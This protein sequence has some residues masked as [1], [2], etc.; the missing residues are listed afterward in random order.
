MET[1]LVLARFWGI[2]LVVLCGSLLVNAKF[3]VRLV[4]GFQDE[5]V[6]FLYFFVVLVIGAVNVSVVNQ[7]TWNQAGLITLLGWGS[8]LKGSFGIL[9]PDFSNKIIQKVRMS[10]A[11]IYP[12]G[13]VFLLV[14]CYL[15]FCGFVYKAGST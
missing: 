1:S 7:W 9:L 2:I 5:S 10:P 6:R 4:K 15:L 12:S 14:G 8:L 13:A 3:Y 11:V